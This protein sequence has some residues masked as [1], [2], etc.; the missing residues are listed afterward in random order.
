M[1]ATGRALESTAQRRATRHLQALLK[2]AP[3]L[4]PALVRA[5]GSAQAVAPMSRAHAEI[6]RL[7]R[8]LQAQEESHLA[9]V[10]D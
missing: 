7:T 6:G 2:R 9:L 3:E 8:R 10:A 1:L 4:Y 5:L